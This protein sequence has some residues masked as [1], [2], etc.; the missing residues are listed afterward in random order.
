MRLFF[1]KAKKN[2][3]ARRTFLCLECS[4]YLYDLLPEQDVFCCQ[5]TVAVVMAQEPA[6]ELQLLVDQLQKICEG[7]RL[8]MPVHSPRDTGGSAVGD[9]IV[10]FPSD[11]FQGFQGF[12]VFRVRGQLLQPPGA[13]QNAEPLAALIAQLSER[14]L[15]IRCFRV[16]DTVLDIVA[17]SA[18]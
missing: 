7:V 14:L 16:Q 8:I 9:H 13:A 18:P 5:D 15:K 2:A 17:L 12:H 6:F 4:K 1:I 10:C 3:T 11:P